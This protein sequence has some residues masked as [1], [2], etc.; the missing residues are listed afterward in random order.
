[1]PSDAAKAI[2]QLRTRWARMR[3]G[4]AWRQ[5]A[6][7]VG[8]FEAPPWATEPLPLG[9]SAILAGL[10][11]SFVLPSPGR[12]SMARV[13]VREVPSV[14]EHVDAAVRWY[15]SFELDTSSEIE[16]RTRAALD[17]IV[18][19]DL[20]HNA[21]TS[22]PT[23]VFRHLRGVSSLDLS[24]N[25]FA[26]LPFA[27]G[28]LPHLQRLVSDGN[29]LCRPNASALLRRA[30]AAPKAR[31]SVPTLVQIALGVA[32]ASGVDA[33]AL[34]PH[35]ADALRH[36]YLCAARSCRSAFIAQDDPRFLNE[37]LYIERLVLDQ[38][39][40]FGGSRLCS[41]CIIRLR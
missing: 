18:T 31:Q 34:P 26:A 40:T 13:Y 12:L 3:E 39:L 23:A 2:V 15:Q 25:A 1:M 8:A 32:K 41:D 7:I 14:L 9:S 4:E 11:A 21:L 16:A 20:S 10:E 6:A 5:I 35:L 27:I 17:R 37:P 24:H 29:P 22:V 33:D 28:R 38:R 30:R 19:L 36:G